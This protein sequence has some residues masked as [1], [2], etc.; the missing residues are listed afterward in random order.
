MSLLRTLILMASFPLLQLNAQ[1]LHFININA[2]MGLPSNECYRIAQDKRGYIWISTDA[3]LVKYNSKEFVLF[4]ASKG[5]PSINDIYALDVDS[6][7]RLW[8]ATGK[9]KIGYIQDDKVTVLPDMDFFNGRLKIADIIYKIR[10][11]DTAGCL[12]VSTHYQT[13][14]ISKVGEKYHS[15]PLNANGRTNDVILINGNYAANSYNR[16]LPNESYTI[17]EPTYLVDKTQLPI[18]TPHLLYGHNVF[19]SDTTKQG[20]FIISYYSDLLAFNRDQQSFTISKY[21]TNEILCLKTSS[22]NNI[23]AGCKRGGAFIFRNGDIIGKPI[24]VLS[25]LSV[26]NIIEDREGGM[27]ATTLEHGVYY[28]PNPNVSIL[29]HLIGPGT[30]VTFTKVAGDNLFLSN[31]NTPLAIIGKIEASFKALGQE[32]NPIITDVVKANEL[33]YIGTTHGFYSLH[34]KAKK[35]SKVIKPF[36]DLQGSSLQKAPNGNKGMFVD[37]LGNCFDYNTSYLHKFYNGQHVFGSSLGIRIKH[38]LLLNNNEALIAD[39]ESLYICSLKDWSTKK[40]VTNAG[41]HLHDINKIFLDSSRNCWVLGNSDSLFVLDKKFSLKK[42]IPLSTLKISSCRNIVQVDGRTFYIATNMGLLQLRFKDDTF[43]SYN[44]VTFNQTNGLQSNDVYHVSL[45]QN[46]VYISTS[47]GVCIVDS[48]QRLKHLATPKTII[49]AF[50]VN[51]SSFVPS[52]ENIFSHKQKNFSFQVD[53]LTFKKIGQRGVFFKYKL[54][55]WDTDFKTATGNTITFNNL[56]TG[57]YTFIAKAFYDADAEDSTPATFSFTIKPAFWQTWWGISLM[58][59]FTLGCIFLFVQWRIRKI[60]LVEKEK[61]AINQTIAEYRFTALKAQMDPHFIFN[62]VNVIQNLILEKDKTEAYNSLEK[63]SRLIRMVLNQSDSVFATIEEEMALINLYVQL[64]QLRVDYPFTFETD[65][66]PEALHCAVPSLIIQP[67]IENSLW[68]GILPLK[69]IRE[70]KILLK[71]FLEG[72]MLIIEIMDNGVGRNVAKSNKTIV[73][74]VSKGIKL[75]EER[76]EAYRS[77]NNGCYAE[78]K[79]ID[80]EE[81]GAPTGTLVQ[82]KIELKEEY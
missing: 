14:V 30:S 46:K 71:V 58:V 29:D 42:I 56:P 50:W 6:N 53:A 11:D 38:A 17:K 63:F 37:S 5:M 10:Y 72:N 40:V 61:A 41:R 68:H 15:K 60:R 82:I 25:N 64:N 7:G 73:T 62:S 28:C 16:F 69:G 79:I 51:D 43:D 35:F 45:F 74:H 19:F 9:W 18:P 20:T 1:D 36:Q 55:G 59:L 27:W 33:F 3:G 78:L 52:T 54:A 12:Y 24:H 32:Q 47:K 44:L 2:D 4:N 8:F 34:A 48:V 70:G 26:S 49:N 76:L 66:Q 75:I 13:I 39:M 21:L 67:F 65:I 23:W 80:M 77:M 81:N 31:Q 57:T 22:S